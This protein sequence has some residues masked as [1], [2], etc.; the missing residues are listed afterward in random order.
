MSLINFAERKSKKAI[1]ASRWTLTGRKCLHLTP[2]HGPLVPMSG[3]PLPLAICHLPLPIAHCHSHCNSNFD[4]EL[5]CRLIA[6]QGPYS[7][8]YLGVRCIDSIHGPWMNCW[9][10]SACYHTT[11][12]VGLLS[13]PADWLSINK[14]CHFHLHFSCKLILIFS[15][16]CL[17]VAGEF[18]AEIWARRLFFF[19]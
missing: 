4:S 12:A 14:S 9:P 5:N 16:H 10:R 18:Y 2:H 1:V 15:L 6:E 3:R 19:F 8:H 7:G 13:E 17:F 11:M